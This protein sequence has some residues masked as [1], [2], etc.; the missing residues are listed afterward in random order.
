MLRAF[1]GASINLPDP[2]MPDIDILRA[3][4]ETSF[5]G[6]QRRL[7]R[8]ALDDL[9]GSR[10]EGVSAW[11]HAAP[12]IDESYHE[13][14]VSVLFMVRDPYSWIGSLFRHPY[15]IR[16]PRLDTLEGFIQ[17]P[18]LTMQRDNVDPVL[19][20][21]MMLWNEKLR[22]YLAFMDAA[23]VP[24][25]VLK[26]EDFVLDPVFALSASLARFGV[27]GEGLEEVEEPTKVKG[28]D[29][30]NRIEY[31]QSAAW[32]KAISPE[33]ANLINGFVDWD[34]AA[35]FGYKLRAPSEFA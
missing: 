1:E 19:H 24:T 9:R 35:R 13:N 22:A 18:W 25:T 7:Y 26:F 8:N 32:K 21:P 27:S 30:K 23:I 3:R 6:F 31:Y 15:H 11:K 20:S 12:T 33:T 14:L 16:G 5:K 2:T 17:Q 10:L 28:V 34:V 4:I 29:R